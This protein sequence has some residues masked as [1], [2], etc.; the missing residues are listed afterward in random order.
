MDACWEADWHS[1][2]KLAT[3]RFMRPEAAPLDRGYTRQYSRDGTRSTCLHE[4]VGKS[5]IMTWM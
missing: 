4:V 1:G 2:S 5:R 3:A